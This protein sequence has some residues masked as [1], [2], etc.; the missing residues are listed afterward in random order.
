MIRD[1][2]QDWVIRGRGW[3]G[4]EVER[5]G[6]KIGGREGDT[7]G[8]RK[9]EVRIEGGSGRVKIGENVKVRGRIGGGQ[10]AGG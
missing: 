5:E 3:S 9:V 1:E 4:D 7:R 2:G 6:T 10:W 8:G